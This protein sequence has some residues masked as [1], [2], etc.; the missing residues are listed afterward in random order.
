M[1]N[2]SETQQQSSSGADSNPS[3]DWAASDKPK[4]KRTRGLRVLDAF[5]YPFLNN[6]AVFA[7]SAYA[8]YMTKNGDKHGGALNNWLK[9]RGD[10]LMNTFKGWGMN[11]EQSEMSKMVFFS[12]L[13]GSIMA[14]VIK[15]FEDKRESIARG[16]DTMFGTVPEDDSVYA[17]EPKQTW[18]SVLLGRAAT[19][20]IIVPIAVLMDKKKVNGQIK[21]EKTGKWGNGRV[22]LN[23][24]LF[25]APGEKAGERIV[26]H[27]PG[28]KKRFPK[29]DW[30]YLLKTGAFEAF[31][32][33]VCTAGLYFS[34]RLIA[35]HD[36]K[37][38][39]KKEPTQEAKFQKTSPSSK[40]TKSKPAQP[41]SMQEEKS[42]SL[43]KEKKYS[44]QELENRNGHVGKLDAEPVNPTHTLTA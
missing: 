21:N 1:Q 34:S 5:I 23:A 26:K 43:P 37:A 7:I 19:A 33:S 44:D 13:D 25:E 4:Q 39:A 6:F 30:P 9:S 38:K 22:S 36:D 27:Y 11:E 17:A 40:P 32:T 16:L 28:I 42:D 35:K 29:I 10:N 31:Y 14:P 20:A 3:T 24:K 18:K 8:T 2:T 41:V 12:F 15:L